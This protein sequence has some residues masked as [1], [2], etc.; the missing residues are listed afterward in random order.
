MYRTII[1]FS[2]V[3][4][5]W[6]TYNRD[7]LDN[8]V[9]FFATLF[10]RRS[11]FKFSDVEIK[12]FTKMFSEDYGLEIPYHP[13]ITILNKCKKYGL[14]RKSFKDYYVNVDRMNEIEFL[15]SEQGYEDKR[16]LIIEK[17]VSYAKEYYNVSIESEVA[18]DIILCSLKNND[19]ELLFARN[20]KSLIPNIKLPNKYKH[21]QLFYYKFVISLFESGS[22]L[23]N[24]LT[25]IAFGH[26]V[27]SA[28]LIED[29]NYENDTV[30]GCSIYIDTPIIIKLLG[31]EGEDVSEI[32]ERHFKELTECGASLK[33][34]KHTN[35][36]IFELLES[37]RNWV[38][39]FEFD[40]EMAS[41]T[42]LYFRQEGYSQIKVQNFINNV[43][44][45]LK[46]NNI[47]IENKPDYNSQEKYQ[48]DE[49]MLLQIIENIY[50][51]INQSFDSD[52]YK[53]RTMRDVDSISAIYRL[54]QGNTPRY[55]RQ[56]K[57]CFVTTNSSIA[58]ANQRYKK[59]NH[60]AENELPACL[61]DV[62]VG[63]ILWIKKPKIAKQELREKFISDC[64]LSLRPDAMLEKRLI[65]E[66]KGL[67]EKRKINNDDY[68]LLT[69]SFLTKELL[70]AKALNQIETFDDKTTFEILEEIKNK[71][72]NEEKIKHDKTLNRLKEE[73]RIN[74]GLREKDNK[75]HVFI[76]SLIHEKSRRYAN[77]KNIIKGALIL[78][79]TLSPIPFIFIVSPWVS[80]IS[81]L[82]GAINAYL[83]YY[84]GFTFK[85][86]YKK[87]Y[88]YNS[89][90]LKSEF[91]LEE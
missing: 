53:L 48:I 46:E 21:L 35:D 68:I 26:I 89:S 9:P 61:T 38:E 73:E 18:N 69:T 56:A 32:Y 40:P 83:S 24:Y 39:A 84:K 33:I 2:L 55:L 30:K 79:T 58:K 14:I 82:A 80:V 22:I 67:L 86:N 25:D 44:R 75:R 78:G 88:E 62:F 5:L 49:N 65:V 71:I 74:E 36:E 37:S 13:L 64:Y 4:A 52:L 17:F 51:E 59:Y 29:Y 76:E 31:G 8:F 72:K 11:I 63:T 85:N 66:A 16:K 6:E 45:I 60:I 50:K 90:K 20:S 12:K 23:Y 70:S 47:V 7:Y 42:T 41:R 34:F 87:A 19:I 10:K 1:S 91:G 43:D 3:S 15:D 81:I 27:A 77:L 54:R 28:I 57:Y